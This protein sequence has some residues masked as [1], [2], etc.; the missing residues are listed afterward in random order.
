M[1]ARGMAC[2]LPWA[3]EPKAESPVP[4]LR[5]YLLTTSRKCKKERKKGGRKGGSR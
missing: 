1:C 5:G 4:A 3:C 2:E